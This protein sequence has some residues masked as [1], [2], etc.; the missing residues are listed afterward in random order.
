MKMVVEIADV[1]TAYATDARKSVRSAAE[2]TE[3]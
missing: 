1:E 2:F 3:Y